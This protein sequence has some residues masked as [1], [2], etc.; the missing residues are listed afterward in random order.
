MKLFD[1]LSEFTQPL[2]PGPVSLYV[3]GV[4]PYD[5]THLGHAFTFVQFDTLVRALRW[6]GRDVRYVQN[7]TDI[8]DSILARAR[9]E[10]VNWKR[11]GDQQSEQ[12]QADMRRLNVASPTHLVRATSAIPT[13]VEMIERLVALEAAYPADGSSVFFRV[14]SAPTYGELS[15]LS[16]EQML[17]IASQQ[18][19][20][21]LDD[22]R[23]EDP[24]DFALWKG[25]SGESDEPFWPSPWGAGRPGWHIECSALCYQH[26]GP[27]LTIHGGGADLRFPHHESEIAQSERFTGLRPFVRLWMHAAMVCM[28]GAKMSKSL[29]NMVFLRDLLERYS[30]D[31]LRVYLLRHHYR[32]VWEWSPAELDSAAEFARAL[33]RAGRAPASGSSDAFAAALDDDLHTA[34]A[35]ESLQSTAGTTLRDLARVL[36]LTLQD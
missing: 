21:D 8:D 28:D 30:A 26:F 18:D 27:R 11:L 13:M 35:L 19:D 16:R 2:A 17:E 31:A 23:K 3:C 5:T 6:R 22:P 36:G 29:G 9:R 7:I 20:A 10:G 32:E 24:L 34:R 33:A 25:W 15:K 14:R 12:Y 1:T 4:T